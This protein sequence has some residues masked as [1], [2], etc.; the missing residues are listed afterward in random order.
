[1]LT[2]N[3]FQTVPYD[4]EMRW[5]NKNFGYI[6]FSKMRQTQFSTTSDAWEHEEQRQN[7]QDKTS[8]HTKTRCNR[9]S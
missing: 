4:K 1:M 3:V 6:K 7:I 5:P 2:S 9:N 8:R